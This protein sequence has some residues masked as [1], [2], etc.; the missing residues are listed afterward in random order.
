MYACTFKKKREKIICV[1]NKNRLYDTYADNHVMSNFVF[2]TK[3]S[4]NIVA[5]FKCL[6][7][8]QA[9]IKSSLRDFFYAVKK[10]ELT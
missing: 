3:M 6:L 8:I 1:V 10:E 4:R 9:S 2:Y 5:A 7:K